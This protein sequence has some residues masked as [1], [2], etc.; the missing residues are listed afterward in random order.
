GDAYNDYLSL[1]DSTIVE[2]DR[3]IADLRAAVFVI[4]DEA[5]KTYFNP[6]GPATTLTQSPTSRTVA[7]E[8]LREVRFAINDFRDSRV[9]RQIG[10]RNSLFLV[11]LA[12]AAVTYLTLGL[13]ILAGVSTVALLSASVY[14]LVAAVAGLLN[15]LRIEFGRTTAVEDFGLG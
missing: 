8:I 12:G 7:R 9:D 1:T 13:A 11:I 15:R 6:P 5:A 14:F 3:L 10:S 2:R 4:S